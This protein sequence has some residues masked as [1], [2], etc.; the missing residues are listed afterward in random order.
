M[1]AGANLHKQNLHK[2]PSIKDVWSKEGGG[3]S[4]KVDD[5]GRGGVGQQPDV[6]KKKFLAIKK[7]I[8]ARK[9]CQFFF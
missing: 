3:V 1:W 7:K 2:G 6:Q 8:L 9:C 4:A 5:L